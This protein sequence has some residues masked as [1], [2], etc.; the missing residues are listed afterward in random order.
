MKE[1]TELELAQEVIQKTKE[2][3][4]K[5]YQEDFNDFIERAKADNVMIDIA[6]EAKQ[7]NNDIIQFQRTI[8]IQAL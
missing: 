6:V 4:T 1:K 3:K 2:E 5:K 7:V 8:I